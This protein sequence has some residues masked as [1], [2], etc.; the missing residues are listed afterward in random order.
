MALIVQRVWVSKEQLEFLKK[1]AKKL[2]CSRSQVIRDG[3][4]LL[5]GKIKI[6]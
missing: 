4:D 3:V 2:K 1:T 6:K 5:R